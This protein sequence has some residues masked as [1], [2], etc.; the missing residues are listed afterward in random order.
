[1]SPGVS[2]LSQIC[3]A[4]SNNMKEGFWQKTERTVSGLAQ[5][6]FFQ[7]FLCGKGIVQIPY[8]KMIII[9]I[10]I[11]IIFTQY[12][13]LGALIMEDTECLQ[14]IERR[15]EITRESFL[16]LKGLKKSNINMKTKRRLLKTYCWNVPPDL[17]SRV[18][19]SR[20]I[21]TACCT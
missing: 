9:I 19:Q 16:E 3:F 4:A 21:K 5:V 18:M 11:I 1:M 13:Y 20:L 15:M 8:R 17:Q 7:V 6:P 14:E 12:K 10:I 2:A